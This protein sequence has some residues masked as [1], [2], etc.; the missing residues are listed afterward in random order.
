MTRV[1]R[2]TTGESNCEWVAVAIQTQYTFAKNKEV[3]TKVN[4]YLQERDACLRDL[5][6]T[7][8]NICE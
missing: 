7:D 5:V 1:G 6:H 4:A 8:I 3:G 2:S